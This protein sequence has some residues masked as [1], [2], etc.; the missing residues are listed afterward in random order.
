VKEIADKAETQSRKQTNHPEALLR[1][2]EGACFRCRC[3]PKL[4]EGRMGRQ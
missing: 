1:G 2:R 4:A 3:A